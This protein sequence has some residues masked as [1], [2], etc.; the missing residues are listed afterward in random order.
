MLKQD[1]AYKQAIDVK[2]ELETWVNDLQ[3]YLKPEKVHWCDGS[4]EEYNNLCQQLVDKGTFIKLNPEKRPNSYACFSD[5]SDVARVEDKTFICS[6]RK[7]DAGPTNNWMAPDEMKKIFNEL[8]D[9]CMKGRTMYVI[10]FCMG[11]VGSPLSRYGIEIT[12][13]EYVVTNMRIMTRMGAHIL[14]Y[15][16]EKGYVK[17]LHTIGAP[18][19][20]GQQDA[21]WPCNPTV[22]YISHFPEERLIISYGSG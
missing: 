15:I 22:K 12:D 4:E 19:E 21:K 11:P 14:P 3:Q 20:E 8:L 6:R 9:G 16:Y 5:P 13:S 10:P 1:K 18:L 17:C 7:E 2:T